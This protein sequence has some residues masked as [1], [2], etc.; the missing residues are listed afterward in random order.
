[1][2]ACSLLLVQDAQIGLCGLLLED[3]SLLIMLEVG[4]QYAAACDAV[5]RFQC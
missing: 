1:M 3:A 4:A 5:T 2:T